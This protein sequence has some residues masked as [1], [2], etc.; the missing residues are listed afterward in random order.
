[1][2]ESLN[3]RDLVVPTPEV[4][5]GFPQRLLPKDGKAAALLMK[6][7]LTDLYNEKPAWLTHAHR[8]LDVAVADANGWSWPMTN[9]EIL[10]NCRASRQLGQNG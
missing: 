6:R 4:V 3:P 10:M 5:T 8:D 2:A 7:T 9:E 1:V